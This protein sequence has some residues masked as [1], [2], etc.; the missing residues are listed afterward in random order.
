MNEKEQRMNDIKDRNDQYFRD[1]FQD[2]DVA[3]DQLIN[4]MALDLLTVQERDALS[5]LV[6][7]FNYAKESLA[8][9]KVTEMPTKDLIRGL[10]EM[11]ELKISD[12][13]IAH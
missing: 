6:E 13:G 1:M 3:A 7:S 8:Y 4:Q 11:L 5:I 12:E 2:F 10:R 9:T